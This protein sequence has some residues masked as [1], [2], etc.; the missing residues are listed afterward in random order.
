MRIGEG[1]D[2]II[3]AEEH[4]LA[5]QQK[6]KRLEYTVETVNGRMQHREDRGRRS[7]LWIAGLP[8]KA[9]EADI[10]AF[11]QNWAMY[12]LPPPLL[13]KHIVWDNLIQITSP[14]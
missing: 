9:G 6:V 12:S 7:N 13:S 3:Q 8:E 11:L 14:S 5:L 1:E 4:V 2:R 10:C